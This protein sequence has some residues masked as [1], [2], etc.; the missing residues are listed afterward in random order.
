MSHDLREDHCHAPSFEG[1]LKK[2]IPSRKLD[3]HSFGMSVHIFHVIATDSVGSGGQRNT[4][5]SLRSAS[6]GE[7]QETTFR[8]K[9]HGSYH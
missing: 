4:H 1:Q 7:M 6:T 8:N 9:F 5:S 3:S 2:G